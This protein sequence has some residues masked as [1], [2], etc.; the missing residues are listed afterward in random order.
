M[1]VMSIATMEWV[2]ANSTTAPRIML[3]LWVLKL[4]DKDYPDNNSLVE[5][6]SLRPE[7]RW[8][9]TEEFRGLREGG[10]QVVLAQ[11]G[12]ELKEKIPLSSQDFLLPD[13][14]ALPDKGAAFW[15]TYCKLEDEQKGLRNHMEVDKSTVSGQELK[16]RLV[17]SG[18]FY[19]SDAHMMVV[20]MVSKGELKEVAYDTYV[21]GSS[22]NEG[23]HEQC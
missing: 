15:K 20:D 10:G 4:V 7:F 18:I 16:Q 19:T 22:R 17:S 8:F 14:P 6:I 2:D 21:R 1:V 11:T 23:D 3:E 5:Q 13:K 9:I 12:E